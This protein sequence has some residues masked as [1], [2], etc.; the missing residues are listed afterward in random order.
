MSKLILDLDIR[1][2]NSV[3]FSSLLYVTKMK[4]KI[5]FTERIYLNKGEITVTQN[6]LNYNYEVIYRSRTYST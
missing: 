1:I 2:T 6:L 5:D 3:L 4:F